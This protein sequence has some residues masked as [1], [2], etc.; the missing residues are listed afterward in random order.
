MDYR[1]AFRTAH[2]FTRLILLGILMIVSFVV[3]TGLSV[4]AALPFTGGQVLE[5]FS[6]NQS[7][8]GLNLMRYFQIMSHV[9]LFIVPALA[10]AFILSHNPLKYLGFAANSGLRRL[11]LGSL[12][13]LVAA[14]LSAY[15]FELNQHMHFPDG[16]KSVETWMRNMETTAEQMTRYFVAVDTW[17]SLL[18]NVFMIAVIPSIGEELIFRGLIQKL[19]TQWT[20][21]QH[22]AVLI[23]AILFSAMHLQF[24]SFL[25]RFVL[26]MLLGYMFV[27]SGNIWVPIVAH[28]VNNLAALLLFFYFERGIISFDIEDIGATTMAP[29]FALASLAAVIMLFVA[30]RRAKPSA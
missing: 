20:R 24:F 18:F 23:T 6:G 11:V 21:N 8:E 15:V 10:F 14:P 28:F 17:Q 26:G 1:E 9:G 22:I 5:Y 2:P 29:A 19:F 7:A 12:I 30:F 27:W 13:M 25:P 16:L 3:V 4:F